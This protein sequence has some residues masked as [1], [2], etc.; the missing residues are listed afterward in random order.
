[1]GTVPCARR[2]I[3]TKHRRELVGCGIPFEVTVRFPGASFTAQRFPACSFSLYVTAA[4]AFTSE[5]CPSIAAY[6]ARAGRDVLYV[7]QMCSGL[8]PH[9]TQACAHGT[10]PQPL[11]RQQPPSP[12]PALFF[13]PSRSLPNITSH[14]CSFVALPYQMQSP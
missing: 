11:L 4:L 7:Q 14:M 13:S 2:V 8:S 6:T 10:P 12:H 3:R 9:F 5:V 1:M